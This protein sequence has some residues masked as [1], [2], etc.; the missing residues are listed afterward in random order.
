MTSNDPLLTIDE[1]SARLRVPVST[2]R[3]W[4]AT[5]QAPPALKIGRRVLFAASDLDRWIEGQR[6]AS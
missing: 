1:V 2:V 3:Y 5:G 6:D 4:R